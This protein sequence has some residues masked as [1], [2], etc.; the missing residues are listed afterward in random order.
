[1]KRQYLT[2]L[3]TLMC[4]LGLALG[5]RAQEEDAVVAN[6]PYD[7]VVG[8]RVLPAGTY[9]VSPVDFATGTRVLIIG[10]YERHASAFLVP[11]VFDD[12][13]TG[14]THLNFEHVG[15]KYFLNAVETS[16]GTYTVAIPRS[17]IKLAEM[18]H[19]GASSSGSN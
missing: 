14:H 5:A 15:D 4:T 7:F 13:R 18:E 1:M 17:A 12:V 9:K 10:S 19:Q 8:N 3:F 6:V 16:I 2:V 11:T